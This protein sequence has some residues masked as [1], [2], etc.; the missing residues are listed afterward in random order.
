MTK[1]E[2]IPDVRIYCC[3]T[4]QGNEII[5]LADNER[6]YLLN[7]RRLKAG[8]EISLFNAT[9]GQWRAVI[10]SSTKKEVYIKLL[11]QLRKPEPEPD[12]WLF[13]AIVKRDAL[14]NIVQKATELGVSRIIPVITANSQMKN[15][16]I[17][18]LSVIATEAAEQ[19]ERLSVPILEN[20]VSI[21][22]IEKMLGDKKLFW[23]DESGAEKSMAQISDDS[24]TYSAALIIGPEGGF[25]RQERDFLGGIKNSVALCF[26]PRILKAD[27][28]AIVGLALIMQSKF[29]DW[30]LKPQFR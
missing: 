7:V 28:A 29:G 19:C 20:P 27:T 10:E 4:L 23:G 22:H 5:T 30:H 2:N 13:A 14:E 21:T 16:N 1:P 18:R 9:S 15:I 8:N 6:N 17:E 24:E 11:E 3:H 25:T 26:G 12:V